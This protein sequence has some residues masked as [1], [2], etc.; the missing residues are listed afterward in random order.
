MG[1]HVYILELNKKMKVIL[2][3]MKMCYKVT[4]LD[5]TNG[6]KKVV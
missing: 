3:E 2:N 4:V 6:A 1:T 5:V